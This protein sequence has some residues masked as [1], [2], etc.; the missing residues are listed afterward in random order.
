[1]YETKAQFIRRAAAVPNKVGRIKF[2]S[3][4]M[5]ESSLIDQIRLMTTVCHERLSMSGEFFK[6]GGY[7]TSELFR[8]VL[9]DFE[10]AVL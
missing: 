5:Y 8:V 10:F 3:S 9:C 4:T 6:T 2:G 1:M 7:F